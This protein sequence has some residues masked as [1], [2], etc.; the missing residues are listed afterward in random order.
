MVRQGLC[1]DKLS[2]RMESVTRQARSLY[3][4]RPG[5][6]DPATV[7]SHAQTD[8]P[9][10]LMPTMMIAKEP[11]IA[12]RVD[13]VAR[14][15]HRVVWV[16]L[17]SKFAE[18][19]VQGRQVAVYVPHSQRWPCLLPARGAGTQLRATPE[20]PGITRVRIRVIAG[21]DSHRPSR[22]ES[23]GCQWRTTVNGG[24][25]VSPTAACNRNR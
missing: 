10:Y 25:V 12:E 1:A 18:H 13:V 22:A 4:L 17:C 9:A 21:R 2:R 20:T 11:G 8:G 14:E 23:S 7:R 6:S 3:P 19:I 16:H 5:G 15:D 24:V